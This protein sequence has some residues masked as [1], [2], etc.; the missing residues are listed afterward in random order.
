MSDP[1]LFEAVVRPD[2]LTFKKQVYSINLA[3]AEEL[4]G[5][6]F[7]TYRGEVVYVGQSVNVLSRVSSHLSDAMIAESPAKKIFDGAYFI[8]A[9]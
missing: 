8:R 6:Y 5:I 9:Q 2:L 4:S 7:L 3:W 1:K